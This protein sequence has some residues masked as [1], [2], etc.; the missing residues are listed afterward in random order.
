MASFSLILA[1]LFLVPAAGPAGAILEEEFEGK[2]NSDLEWIRQDKDQWR[3]EDGKLVVRSQAGRIWGG[4]DARNLL[5]FKILPA[6]PMA[7]RVLVAHQPKGK[8]EQAGL[9]WYVD[10]NHFVKLISEHIDG[11]M[12]VVVARE[13]AGR[14]KVISKIEVPAA[15]LE[16]RLKVEPDGV[17]GQW[18]LKDGDP[19]S[20]CDK[21]V[22]EVQGKPRFGL[23]TQDG[24]QDTARWVRFDR[25]IIEK[26]P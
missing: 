12:Y 16:L 14:G 6:Q 9:L 18:R 21:F 17:T 26:L 4:N 2:L 13:I 10:D 19:W 1:G 24:P 23:F 5:L 8:Y 11:K 25:L 3:L 22:F 7:A 20:N 15:N